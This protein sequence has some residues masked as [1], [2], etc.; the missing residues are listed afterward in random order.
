MSAFTSLPSVT[1][2]HPISASRTT[3]LPADHAL[4]L[5]GDVC[6]RAE[7][8]PVKRP[9]LAMRAFGNGSRLGRSAGAH[10]DGQVSSRESICSLVQ[11]CLHNTASSSSL[12]SALNA[13]TVCSL[14]AGS[15]RLFPTP[16]RPSPFQHLVVI[17]RVAAEWSNT[18][19]RFPA[20]AR[21]ERSRP[22]GD[23]LP[24]RL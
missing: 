1:F 18:M 7:R 21:T 11:R 10:L 5:L 4:H 20:S 17:V 24:P 19:D 23:C 6:S 12:S 13:L 9:R 8:S 14:Y 2:A 3:A 16:D 22:R 15:Q